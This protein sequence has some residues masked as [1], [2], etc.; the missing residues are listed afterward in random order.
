MSVTVAEEGNKRVGGP[1]QGEVNQC[2]LDIKSWFARSDEFEEPKGASEVDLQRLMKT[3]DVEL[4][5]ALE[6]LLIEANGGLWFMD[7]ASFSA[8]QIAETCSENDSNRNWRAGFLP[9][10]GDDSTLLVID[11][12]GGNE[13]FEYE[14][15]DGLGDCVAPSLGA[16][17]ESYRDQL[18]G[19]TFEFMGGIGCVEKFGGTG[20]GAKGGSRK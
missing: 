1:S 20:G 11:S 19:G 7:K 2:V 4:P 14:I 3:I 10:A 8:A 9:F 12:A 15:D 6:S 18:L 16:Y 13:V 5:R 17:L